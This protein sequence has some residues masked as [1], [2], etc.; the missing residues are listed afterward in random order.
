MDELREADNEINV[1]EDVGGHGGVASDADDGGADLGVGVERERHLEELASDSDGGDDLDRRG[2]LSDVDGGLVGAEP[3]VDVV[4]D[5]LLRAELLIDFSTSEELAVAGVLGVRDGAERLGEPVEVAALEEDAELDR[6]SRVRLSGRLPAHRQ[7]GRGGD[8]ATVGGCDEHSGGADKHAEEQR[9]AHRGRWE[10]GA[11]NFPTVS[12]AV[13]AKFPTAG[14]APERRT[15]CA[16]AV[17]LT[18]RRCP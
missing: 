1:L 18:H 5:L 8:R 7:H 17:R 14:G 9:R 2:E 4:E 16:S 15:A 12:F 6:L 10:T 3:L 11:S 13:L